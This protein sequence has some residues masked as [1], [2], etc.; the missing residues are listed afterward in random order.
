MTPNFTPAG[1][2][3]L[4]TSML[5]GADGVQDDV[6]VSLMQILWFL[7]VYLNSLLCFLIHFSLASIFFFINIKYLFGGV[8]MLELEPGIKL[9]TNY[10]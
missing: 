7:S 3:S 1:L 2:G 4:H 5:V 10:N 9:V 6:Q 8:V